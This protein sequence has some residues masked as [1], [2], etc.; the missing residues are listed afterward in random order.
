MD[1]KNKN[2]IDVYDLI[3]EDYA[4]KFDP[5]ESDD[6]LVFPNTFLSHL[7]IGSKIVDLGCGTGFSANY[8]TKKG[9][10]AMGVDLSKSMIAIA[11]RNYPNIHF[12]I[13]DV[14]QFSFSNQIDAVWAGYSLFH[15][16]KESLFK[17]LE[18]IKTYL[19]PGGILGLV[20]QEG[21]G[22]IENDEPFL[23]GRKIYIHLYTKEELKNILEKY[24]FEIIE[25]KIKKAHGFEFPYDKLLLIARLKNNI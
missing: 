14:R 25:E 2:A 11:K 24:G 20:M 12:F 1:E 9:M 7:K 5:I 8:F 4:K 6:D 16:E 15:F 17:T 10:L 13:E 18:Q 3:A 19:L 22:E 21:S 23:P